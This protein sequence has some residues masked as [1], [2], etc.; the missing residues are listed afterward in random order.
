MPYTGKKPTKLG[1]AGRFLWDGIADNYELRPDEARL[2]EDAAREA[3]L[4]ERLETELR[5]SELTSLGSMKQEV[6]SPLVSEIRQ[7]RATLAGLLRQL[8]LPDAKAT[9]AE[10]DFRQRRAMAGANSRWHGRPA[11]K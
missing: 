1:K 11:A 10:N 6:S 8:K 7:H 4:I 2:L 3:D 9:V 5:T